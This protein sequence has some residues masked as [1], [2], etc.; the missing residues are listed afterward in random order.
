MNILTTLLNIVLFI[1]MLGVLVTIHELGHFAVAKLFKVY[2]FEFSIGFGPKIFPWKN[3]KVKEGKK[4]RET[5][6]SVRALPL[7][8]F[9]SMYGEEGAVPE[10]FEEANI[11]PKR[12]L[13]GVNRGKRALIMAA[14][15]IMN[16]ILGYTIFLF[17]NGAIEQ[18]QLVTRINVAE[19]SPLL[20][21]G[22]T[23]EKTWNID[24]EEKELDGQTIQYFGVG[25][26]NGKS[27]EYYVLFQPTSYKDLSF[28]GSSLKLVATNTNKITNDIFYDDFAKD[29]V[30]NFQAKFYHIVDKDSEPEII[31]YDASIETIA[32]DESKPDGAYELGGLGFSLTTYNYRN[33]FKQTFAKA[34]KDFV[35]SATAVIKGLGSIFK[36]GLDGFSGPIGIFNMSASVLKNQGLANFLFLWGL[37]SI[38][39]ALFNLLPFPPLDG[40]HLLVVTVEA[41]TRREISPKFKNIAS[42][43][44]AIIMILFTILIIGKDI[45]TLFGVFL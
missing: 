7:G 37:I 2:V 11:D 23:N 27:Q 4:P 9:V 5:K 8:G 12:S 36:S 15:I 34:N 33:N 44:G 28:S 30:L 3:M 16:L 29:D 22:I 6:F 43:I 38:N 31:V 26:L 1:V 32:V 20:S 19:T 13:K 17:S 24:F 41:I 40:W 14:G 21:A 42:M 10:G 35:N 39:L 45:F 18:T 25:T